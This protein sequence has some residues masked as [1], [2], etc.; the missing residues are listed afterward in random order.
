MGSLGLQAEDKIFYREWTTLKILIIC[1]MQEI[2][3]PMKTSFYQVIILFLYDS[4]TVSANK[5][6]GK[7]LI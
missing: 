1:L 3:D 4:T 7:T 5:S 6:F 2:F